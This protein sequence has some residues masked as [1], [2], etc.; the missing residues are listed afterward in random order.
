MAILSKIT[1]ADKVGQVQIYESLIQDAS[2]M[3]VWLIYYEYFDHYRMF[4]QNH[5]SGKSRSSSKHESLTQDA[6]NMQVWYMYY[7]YFA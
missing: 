7:V 6:S 4:K 1:Q 5:S 3:Q 2:N